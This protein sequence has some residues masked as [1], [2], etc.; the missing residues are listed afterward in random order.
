MRERKGQTHRSVENLL[1]QNHQATCK[2]NHP[3]ASPSLRDCRRRMRCLVPLQ[4]RSS[5][6][7]HAPSRRQSILLAEH[8]SL[9]LVE[10]SATVSNLWK[11]LEKIAIDNTDWSLLFA[12]LQPSIRTRRCTLSFLLC[13]SRRAPGLILLGVYLRE[14][15]SKVRAVHTMA[16]MERTYWD[17]Y[18]ASS[19]GQE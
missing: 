16:A 3:R 18:G 8:R 15:D 4:H 19:I 9:Q 2:R 14:E 12:T 5:R 17:L 11:T 13:E 1:A 10:H 6:P 7:S